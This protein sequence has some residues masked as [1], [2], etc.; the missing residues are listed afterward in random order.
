MKSFFLTVAAL[1]LG[2]ISQAQ[3]TEKIEA[4]RPDQT[5]TPFVVPRNYFQAEFGF[6]RE[7]YRTG[8][9]QF[10]HPTSL[11]KYGLNNKIE[12]RLEATYLRREEMLIPQ[13]KITTVLE[14]VE[15]G[16]KIALA[17]E[18][19]W[20]PKTSVL[21]HVGMPFIADKQ[22]HTDPVNF[23]AIITLQNTL[24]ETIAIGYN[25]GVE[26]GNETSFI[27]TLSPG[28]SLSEKWYGYIEVF[29]SVSKNLSEQ[30]IDMGLA[31]STSKNTKVDLSAG[32]GLGNAPLKHYVA[33]GFSF[34]IPVGKH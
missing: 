30:N 28:F 31:Y 7:S 23:S 27:Y 4:D 2:L 26:G 34:R 29:G 1:I 13:P 3:L 22:Y 16:T 17:E 21:V 25:L 14:P 12:L 33:F 9:I 32:F 6:N 8:V 10:L 19:G 5:E 11:L 18:K 20:R 24:S 15:I